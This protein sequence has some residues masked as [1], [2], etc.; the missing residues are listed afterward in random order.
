MP[1]DAAISFRVDAGGAGAAGPGATFGVHLRGLSAEEPGYELRFRPSAGE[2]SLG[3][4]GRSPESAANW[5]FARIENMPGLAAPFGVE[6]ILKDDLIDVCIDRRQTL[7]LR[8]GELRG[9][10]MAFFL[11]VPPVACVRFGEFRGC[12]LR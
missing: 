7:C 11:E 12:P 4:A 9:R 6:I 1:V 8:L 5:S 3:R 10:R 2:F